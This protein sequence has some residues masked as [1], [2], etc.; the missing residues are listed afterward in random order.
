MRHLMT[1]AILAT[2]AIALPALADTPFAGKTGALSFSVDAGKSQLS[3][4]SDAP[5][6]KFKGT[7]EG[8]TGDFKVAD[9]ANP[10]SVTGK[11]VV[12]VGKMKTGNDLRDTH[13][14]SPDWLNAA[15]NPNITFEIEKAELS[16]IEGNRASGKAHG[17]FSLNGKT[18]GKDLSI[19]VA[20][21]GDRNAIKVTAKFRVSLKD[22]DI[23]GKAGVAGSKVGEVIE[24]EATLYGAGK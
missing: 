9:A 22:H 18:I 1:A 15:A 13:M 12:P 20:Y 21:A 14:K 7:A 19:D 10:G 4:L 16:K 17:K 23:K 8:I 5:M 6:E 11:I 2:S 24:V 3:F